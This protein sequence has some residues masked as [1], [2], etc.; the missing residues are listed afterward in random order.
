MSPDDRSS[1][2]RF[3]GVVARVGLATFTRATIEGREHV[4]SSGPLI[5]AANHLSLAD[6]IILGGI[7]P[8]PVRFMAKQE[9]LRNPLV[10]VLVPWYGAFTVRRGE[11]DRV[12]YRRALRVLE[13]GEVLGLF[14]EGTRSRTGGLQAA[15]SGVGLLALRTGA[16]IIPVGIVGTEHLGPK[17]LLR[18]RP[19]V[20]V[21]IGRPLIVDRHERST[22]SE[23]A[24]L[25]H[26]MMQAIAELLPPER[27]GVYGESGLAASPSGVA[28][29]CRG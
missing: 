19:T 26:E 7:F 20:I 22:R 24:R 16:P 6:P 27:R 12:A 23:A 17:R 2:Y 25:T 1:L 4:P 13:D 21:R 5:L 8:R 11:A 14:P 9:L 28:P 15:R 3:G 18:S 10:S 29:T